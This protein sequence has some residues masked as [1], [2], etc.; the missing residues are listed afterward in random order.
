MIQLFQ[1]QNGASLADDETVPLQI[2]GARSVLEILVSLAQRRQAMKARDAEG[3]NHAVRA[4][5]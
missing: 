3:M 2:K 5:A 1:H 4:A